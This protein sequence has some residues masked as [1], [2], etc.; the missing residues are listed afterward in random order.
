MDIKV[1]TIT[2]DKTTCANHYGKQAGHGGAHVLEMNMCFLR[3]TNA[4][5]EDH[6]GSEKHL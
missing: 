2:R 3:C 5:D 4:F 6:V 1:L